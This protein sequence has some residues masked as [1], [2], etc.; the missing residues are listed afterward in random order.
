MGGGPRIVREAP[1]V[2]WGAGVRGCGVAG[3]RGGGVQWVGGGVAGCSVLPQKRLAVHRHSSGAAQPQCFTARMLPLRPIGCMSKLSS[4]F[5]TGRVRRAGRAGCG[6]AGR[7][8]Q[9]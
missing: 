6:H 3:W 4:V 7:M 9:D 1:G 8:R 2:G 5:I